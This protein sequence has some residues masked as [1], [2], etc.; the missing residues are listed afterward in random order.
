MPRF[1]PETSA[2][3]C[4]L[5][6]DSLKSLGLF[7]KQYLFVKTVKFVKSSAAFLILGPAPFLFGGGAFEAAGFQAFDLISNN[8]CSLKL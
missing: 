1:A 7:T 8:G 4:S 3:G 2:K 5:I 6:S